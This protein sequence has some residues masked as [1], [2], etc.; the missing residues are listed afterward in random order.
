MMEDPETKMEVE[1]LYELL[2]DDEKKQLGKNNKA[3]IT[4]YNALPHQDYSSKNHVRK[5][6]CALPLKWRAKV[7]AIEEAKD[8]ATLPLD[9]LIGNLKVYEMILENDGVTSKTTKEKVKSLSLKA[10]VTREQT[11]DDSDSQR[12]S[13]E[14]VNK[15]ETEAFNLIVRNF[16]WSDNEDGDE[17]QND[18]TCLMA[19]N[20][21]EVRPKPSTSNN[22]VDLFE[23]QMDNEELLMFSKDFSKTYEKLLKEK[24]ALEKEHSKLFSKVNK[25]ELEVKNLAKSKEVVEPCQKC[26]V[27]THEVDSLKNIVSKLQDEALNFSKFKKS[28]VVLDDMLS[29]QKLSQDKEGLGFFKTKETT[30]VR[31]NKQITFVKE[32]QN[33]VPVKS[34]PDAPGDASAR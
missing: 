16:P 33:G 8:L 34:A 20:S 32:G 30:S 22:N 11:S 14:D 21:Q 2:K 18:A 17:P 31:L 10:K 15:D 23:L 13:D 3:K 19:V 26:E 6:L 7:T 5:F 24:Y 29:R 9:E 4:L 1:T 28:C 25:L 12:G 27:L